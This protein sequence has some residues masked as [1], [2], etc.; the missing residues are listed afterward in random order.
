LTDI[1]CELIYLV[2]VYQDRIDNEARRA[3][4][5]MYKIHALSPL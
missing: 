5:E 2:W 3:D 4:K 1:L